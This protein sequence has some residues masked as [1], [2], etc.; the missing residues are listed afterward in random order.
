MK[1][2][3]IGMTVAGTMFFGLIAQTM[4]AGNHYEQP[5]FPGYTEPA[6]KQVG[7]QP[8][9]MSVATKAAYLTAATRVL[10]KGSDASDSMFALI[11]EA[12]TDIYIIFDPEWKAGIEDACGDYNQ[13]YRMAM[14]LK[15]P[16][17]YKRHRQYIV[18]SYKQMTLACAEWDAFFLDYDVERLTQIGVYVEK[19]TAYLTKANDLDIDFTADLK[20]AEDEDA[21]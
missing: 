12:S 5:N 10:D 1:T 17:E 9:R 16:V 18:S 21:L 11:E 7:P 14:K 15:A 2:W 3:M 8:L 19:A 6:K 13:A 20:S 4:A